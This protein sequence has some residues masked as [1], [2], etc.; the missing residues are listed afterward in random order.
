M[1]GYPKDV[2]EVYFGDKGI[3]N[4]A[5]PGTYFIDMTTSTPVLA[6][7]IYSAARE[8]G[9]YALDAP[10]SGGDVGAREAKLAIMVGGAAGSWSLS[11]LAPRMIANDFAPGFSV[12]H[13]LKDMGIALVSA[14]ELG[15]NTPGLAL[16]M[17]PYSELAENGEENSGT[18]ALYKLYD[19]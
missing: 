18:Q 13:F 16:A 15:L 14:K 19:K 9:M 10:V 3:I 12:K 1:V 8:R 5:K 7:K 2:E 17:S 6:E 11:N 4:S